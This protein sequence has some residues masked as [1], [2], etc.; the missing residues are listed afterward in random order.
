MGTGVTNL[1]I[2]RELWYFGSFISRIHEDARRLG[3]RSSP[4]F[5]LLTPTVTRVS[6]EPGTS[7]LNRHPGFEPGT[8]SGP[9]AEIFTLTS[10][11]D[12]SFELILLVGVLN[13][14]FPCSLLWRPM[15]V[16]RGD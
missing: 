6:F 5:P 8:F 2:R 12:L 7:N 13:Q 11:T 14:G 3:R 10:M 9:L 1:K 4:G 16:P 15:M